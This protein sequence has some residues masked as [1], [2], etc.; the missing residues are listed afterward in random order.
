M[1]PKTTQV[2]TP[3]I[4]LKLHGPIFWLL[5]YQIILHTNQLSKKGINQQNRSRSKLEK[6]KVNK[7]KFFMGIQPP[8][9][10]HHWN[11]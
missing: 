5:Q 9:Q 11:V 3:F 2:N 7:N 6:F 10:M 8:P 1:S 4:R